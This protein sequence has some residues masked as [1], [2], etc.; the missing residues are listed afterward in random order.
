MIGGRVSHYKADKAGVGSWGWVQWFEFGVSGR[1]WHIV[2]VS[3][4][5]DKEGGDEGSDNWRAPMCVY[6]CV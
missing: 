2:C 1:K 5:A 6:M 3:L 4:R